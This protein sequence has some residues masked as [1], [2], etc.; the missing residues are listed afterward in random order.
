[1]RG[2]T[3]YHMQALITLANGVTYKDSDPMF[4]TGIAPLTSSLQIT[5]PSGLPPQPGIQLFDTISF[6]PTPY[7]SNL[8]QAF[9]TDLQ[10]NV[11]WTYSYA[12]SPVNVITPIKPLSNGHFLVVLTVSSGPTDSIIPS[13]TPTALRA[14]HFIATTIHH[15]PLAS[16]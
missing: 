7:N 3:T 6:G 5:T 10:G 9:A 14:I 8:A 4:T 11:I 12:S 15:L 13:T 1:M 2:S 16:L